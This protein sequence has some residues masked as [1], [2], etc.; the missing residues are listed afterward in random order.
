MNGDLR[1]RSR[2]LSVLRPDA[3]D[4]LAPSFVGI[5]RRALYLDRLVVAGSGCRE[6]LVAPERGGVRKS[7]NEAAGQAMEW[8]GLRV[9]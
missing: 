7:C 9:K 4:R 5:S 8:S 2:S 6:L 3:L 1:E